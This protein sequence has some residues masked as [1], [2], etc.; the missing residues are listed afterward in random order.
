M[1][2]EVRCALRERRAVREILLPDQLYGVTSEDA[3]QPEFS[4]RTRTSLKKRQ[5]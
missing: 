4:K 2:Y 3:L 5:G 1:C